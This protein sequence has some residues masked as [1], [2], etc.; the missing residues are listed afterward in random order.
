MSLE[1]HQQRVIDE[2][3][4]LD[5]KIVALYVF[6]EKNA[7]YRS[8]NAVEQDRLR[9]QHYHMRRYSEILGERIQGFP[10]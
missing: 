5:D 10:R 8:L 2:K 3:A 9:S 4:D 7:I 6:I 1:P